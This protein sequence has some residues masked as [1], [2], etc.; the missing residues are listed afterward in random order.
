MKGS[1]SDYETRIASIEEELNQQLADNEMLRDQIALEERKVSEMREQIETLQKQ[2]NELET[3]RDDMVADNKILGEQMNEKA[4]EIKRLQQIV[5]EKISVEQ[6]LAHMVELRREIDQIKIELGVKELEVTALNGEKLAATAQ[7][8]DKNAQIE[9]LEA[10]LSKLAAAEGTIDSLTGELN[11]LK[12]QKMA[13]E[14]ERT[15][16]QTEFDKLIAQVKQS[17]D[18]VANLIKEKD[19]LSGQLTEAER[20]VTECK[21]SKDDEVSEMLKMIDCLTQT[22]KSLDTKNELLTSELADSVAQLRSDQE[23]L[24]KMADE[25][26][27]RLEQEKENDAKFHKTIDQ[28]KT[29]INVFEDEQEV[30][31]RDKQT[32]AV[33]VDTQKSQIVEL[34]S[35]LDG[36]NAELTAIRRE[37]AAKVAECKVLGAESGNTERLRATIESMK[38][39]LQTA[40]DRA[41]AFECENSKFSAELKKQSNDIDQMKKTF[42]QKEEHLKSIADME[43]QSARQELKEKCA[44]HRALTEKVAQMEKLQNESVASAPR[45]K[46]PSGETRKGH[47]TSVDVDNLLRENH[48]LKSSQQRLMNELDDLRTT[49]QQ[50]RKSKRHSTHDDTRRISGFNSNLID[51]HIQTDP[52]NEMCRCIEFDAKIARLKRDILIKDAKFNTFQKHTGVD[53]LKRENE[54]LQKART[55]IRVECDALKRENVELQKTL[56]SLRDEYELQRTEHLRIAPKYERAKQK[57]VK[58]LNAEANS[59]IFAHSSTQTANEDDDTATGGSY[60]AQ[61]NVYKLD[62]KYQACKKAYRQ[63]RESYEQLQAEHTNCSE[64]LETLKRKYEKV[65]LLCVHRQSEIERLQH[66]EEVWRTEM[67]NLQTKY[68]NAKTIIQHR[69]NEIDKLHKLLSISDEN[70]P[71]NGNCS[72]NHSNAGG[73][74]R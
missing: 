34:Q 62:E 35:K 39:K 15:R 20:K 16:Q 74:K 51:V 17:D 19:D 25:H 47:N 72:T 12:Q 73:G 65:K 26:S 69:G 36:L 70:V 27:N 61:M 9:R 33:T 50:I 53:A 21:R 41:A 59:P 6:E 2:L 28:L 68:T 52:V 14:D 58:F 38:S 5:E 24:R 67:E 8:D 48:S 63:M 56:S 32:L 1:L 18:K 4:L 37:L 42:A 49:S 66:A 55:D 31:E 22:N 40:N 43:L 64:T 71:A 23:K 10:G 60:V 3:F 11:G 45:A 44:E 54:E 29:K 7:L 46:R 30:L 57:L 13:L